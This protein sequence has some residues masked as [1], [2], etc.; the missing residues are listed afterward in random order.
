MKPTTTLAQL[1]GLNPCG[2]G[3]DIANIT[4]P[5]GAF[6]AREA[7]DAGV[8]FDDILWGIASLAQSDVDIYRRLQCWLDDCAKHVTLEIGDAYLPVHALADRQARGLDFSRRHL[9]AAVKA[10]TRYTARIAWH[11]ATKA[12]GIAANNG[13]VMA[14]ATG[15]GLAPAAT[16]LAS[17]A[18]YSAKE[19]AKLAEE[20]WQFARLVAWFDGADPAPL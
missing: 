18:W 20:A 14:R 6:G 2:P 9:D 4:L 15:A 13:V 5:A 8:S 10:I 12:A 11:R 1:S 3:I 17:A 19:R 16:A 7:R